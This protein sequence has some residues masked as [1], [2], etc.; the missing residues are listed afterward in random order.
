[1]IY[2]NENISKFIFYQFIIKSMEISL[3]NSSYCTQLLIQRWRS[4][5]L[6]LESQS[7]L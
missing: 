2:Y 1:M 7:V 3:K 5:A 6:Y 4:Y